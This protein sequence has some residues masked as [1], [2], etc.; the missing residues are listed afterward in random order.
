MQP[1]QSQSNL[2]SN[3]YFSPSLQFLCSTK[4]ILHPSGSRL[5]SCRSTLFPK[6]RQSFFFPELWNRDI[7]SFPS[8]QRHQFT[9][10]IHLDLLLWLWVFSASAFS[11]DFGRLSQTIPYIKVCPI[12]N[13]SLGCK[14]WLSKTFK[15]PML[16]PF[17][18]ANDAF[19][20][21]LLWRRWADTWKKWL[22]Q[23]TQQRFCRSSS[24]RDSQVV[25]FY[26]SKRPFHQF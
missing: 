20:Q 19:R 6:S 16:K 7:P 11:S 22:R 18:I 26:F 12:G 8:H 17:L 23:S 10:G 24:N 25:L 4:S 5:E 14:Q 1:D 13:L 21:C 15:T 2:A 3:L 9:G